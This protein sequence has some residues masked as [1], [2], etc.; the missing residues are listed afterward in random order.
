M[1]SISSQRKSIKAILDEKK[2]NR[3][4]LLL[5]GRD[6]AQHYLITQQEQLHEVTGQLA[7]RDLDVIILIASELMEPDRQFL[8]TKPFGL[9][10]SN[11]FQGWLI[12]K[13][14]GVKDHFTQPV[15]TQDLFKLIDSMPMRKQE[16]K[17]E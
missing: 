9:V 7:E 11:D 2:D 12:G 5:Y 14:G 4:V 13:D 8:M 17:H 10:P 1:E 3:R 15:A 6:D 16:M